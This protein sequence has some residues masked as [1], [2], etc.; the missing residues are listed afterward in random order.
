MGRHEEQMRE[1]E[2]G[3][4]FLSKYRCCP[5]MNGILSVLETLDW[6]VKVCDF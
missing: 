2:K 5:T 1:R 3:Y 4:N 6:T